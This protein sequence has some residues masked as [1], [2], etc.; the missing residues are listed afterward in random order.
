MAAQANFAD[1]RTGRGEIVDL[2]KIAARDL[3]PLLEEEICEWRTELDWDFRPSADLVRRYTATNSLG[4]AALMVDGAVAGYG[5]AVLEEPRGIIGDIYIRAGARNPQAECDLFRSLLEALTTTPRITRMESQLMLVTP[6]SAQLIA[7]N[8]STQ[9]ALRL[10]PRCLMVR[11]SSIE[12][13]PQASFPHARFRF[14]RWQD[15]SMHV[16]GTIIAGAYK[17]ETDAEINSQY[18][19][20]AGA[21]RFLSNI[22]EFPGCGTFHPGSSF[23]ASDRATGE[24]AGMVLSSFVASDVG[25]ISQLCVLPGSRGAGLGKEL[26]RAAVDALARHGARSV[27]LTVT[28]SNNTAI[29]LYENFGFQRG[30]LFYAYIWEG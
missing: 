6:D 2:R 10:F 5:Y 22:V 13:P 16:A 28:A 14:D 27:S 15:H 4:G 23:I 8:R 12:L 7:A 18:R 25:H 3:D 26:L 19:S 11:P 17:G 9:H 1:L 24:P 20:P 30:R 29:S 21:R